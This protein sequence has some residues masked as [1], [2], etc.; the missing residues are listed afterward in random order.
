MKTF[1]TALILL[2]VLVVVVGLATPKDYG[3]TTS[4]VIQAP[5]EKVHVYVGDLKRWPEWAPWHD[6]DP[7]IVT[8]FGPKTTGVGASQSWTSQSGDGELTIIRSSPQTGIAYDMAFLADGE[9]YPASVTLT[10]A[11]KGGATEVTWMMEGTWEG[12]MPP[13]MDGWMKL[14][15]PWILGGSFER[16]LAKLKAAVEAG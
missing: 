13:V 12:M 11:N 15:T 14:M 7:T 4:T 6:E 1:L 8:T 9:R 16:G 5:P 3:V 2:V 10:Y